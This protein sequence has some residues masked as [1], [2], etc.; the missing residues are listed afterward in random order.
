MKVPS[1]FGIIVIASVFFLT[2]VSL[3]YAAESS[4]WAQRN[5]QMAALPVGL[6]LPLAYTLPKN[7]AIGISAQYATIQEE[8]LQKQTSKNLQK[9]IV[10]QDV[11][12]NNEAQ[13]NIA[14]VVEDLITSQKIDMVALEGAFEPLDFGVY[15]A[16]PNTD[17][18][19]DI[20]KYFL[21]EKLIGGPSF[22]G[23]THKNK[24]P[25]FVG[26]DDVEHYKANVQAYLNSTQ[27][28]PQIQQEL[29]KTRTE[30]AGQKK[31][32][33]NE[34][35][36]QFDQWHQAYHSGSLSLGSYIRKI[37]PLISDAPKS[38]R[39][40]MTAYELE[41]N[42]DFD[43]V[44]RER[45]TVLEKLIRKIS[46]AD[47]AQLI[48][49][50]ERYEKGHI[51]FG[52][53]YGHVDSLL[54]KNSIDLNLSPAFK[55]YIQYVILSDA[56]KPQELMPLIERLTE[57]IYRQLAKTEEEK[58]LVAQS[59]Q[60]NLT[61]KLINFDLTPAEWEKYK[62]VRRTE[63]SVPSTQYAVLSTRDFENFY[64]EAEIRSHKMV[65]NIQAAYKNI[66]NKKTGTVLLVTGGFHSPHITQLL[67]DEGLSYVLA[68]PKITEIETDGGKSY[69]SIFSR[70]KSSLDDLF[71]GTKL[72]VTPA[73][74]VFPSPQSPR[75]AF[76][77]FY[78]ALDQFLNG[79]RAP[80]LWGEYQYGVGPLNNGDVVGPPIEVGNKGKLQ[81]RRR[82]TPLL[83]RIYNGL[84]GKRKRRNN[85]YHPL[86][87]SLEARAVKAGDVASALM[88]PVE[89]PQVEEVAPP[90]NNSPAPVFNPGSIDAAFRELT[91]QPYTLLDSPENIFAVES[92]QPRAASNIFDEDFGSAL[93]DEE[94]IEAIST[95]RGVVSDDGIQFSQTGQP[96][97]F[98]VYIYGV[99]VYDPISQTIETRLP[100]NPDLFFQA[101]LSVYD[102]PA[103]PVPGSFFPMNF[104]SQ[105]LENPVVVMQTGEIQM[106]PFFE[107]GLTVGQI[108]LRGIDISN[109]NLSSP[110]MALSLQ[111]FVKSAGEFVSFSPLPNS[112]VEVFV[113]PGVSADAF[114]FNINFGGLFVAAIAPSPLPTQKT[115]ALK[116]E[117]QPEQR[118]NLG[119][120]VQLILPYFAQPQWIRD[121]YGRPAPEFKPRPGDPNEVPDQA[122]PSAPVELLPSEIFKN[123]PD[124]LERLS[125][126]VYIGKLKHLLHQTK[127]NYVVVNIPTDNPNLKRVEILITS[128]DGKTRLWSGNPQEKIA[129]SVENDAAYIVVILRGSNEEFIA[130]DVKTEA[131]VTTEKPDQT[132][133]MR[134]FNPANFK[135]PVKPVLP[136]SPRVDGN[137]SGPLDGALDKLESAMNLPA[138]SVRENRPAPSLP[139]PPAPVVVENKPDNV[140]AVTKNVQQD[141]PEVLAETAE[142]RSVL[143]NA[144]KALVVFSAAAAVYVLS[145]IIIRLFH[146]VDWRAPLRI[147]DQ[148]FSYF[149]VIVASVIARY[150]RVP[151]PTVFPPVRKP[152]KPS[153]PVEKPEP[154]QKPKPRRPDP[155]AKPKDK[156][157]SPQLSPWKPADGVPSLEQAKKLATE[158]G[159]N[160]PTSYLRT[161]KPAMKPY[162]L[163]LRIGLLNLMGVNVE[164]VKQ[165][166]DENGKRVRGYAFNTIPLA[167]L[168][169]NR[170]KVDKEKIGNALKWFKEVEV[171]RLGSEKNLEQSDYFVLTDTA[172]FLLREEG[173]SEAVTE[174]PEPKVVRGIIV[175][176]PI[177][178]VPQKN[179]RAVQYWVAHQFWEPETA[180]SANGEIEILSS[181]REKINVSQTLF[182]QLDIRL[183]LIHPELGKSK[184]LSKDELFFSD[185]KIS[186]NLYTK[187]YSYLVGSAEVK[188]GKEEFKK[189]QFNVQINVSNSQG[190]SQFNSFDTSSRLYGLF[191]TLIPINRVGL[192]RV[193][194]V[195]KNNVKQNSTTR[196]VIAP[197]DKTDQPFASGE[198]NSLLT[199][200]EAEGIEEVTILLDSQ[201]M[202]SVGEIYKALK[203]QE[204]LKISFGSIEDY[205][206]PK[207]LSELLKNQNNE[208]HARVKFLIEQ[209]APVTEDFLN[210]IEVVAE[211]AGDNVV[212]LHILLGLTLGALSLDVNLLNNIS[213]DRQILELIRSQA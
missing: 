152:I 156:L 18:A 101:T 165:L 188:S 72:F 107:S 20:A 99:N 104:N 189:G 148:G 46:S 131:T 76:G 27:V 211:E 88:A 47:V 28:K 23:L 30:L 124:S 170:M 109:L 2:Q 132:V 203:K 176:Q 85:S 42:I 95:L 157:K 212:S 207:N 90:I 21:D 161:E 94:V 193:G 178:E 209:G 102:D 162:E 128:S 71:S 147:L 185:G 174:K 80:F 24:I 45:N 64:Q 163:R 115:N 50:N 1:R 121:R 98:E 59:E 116:F 143:Q 149:S 58:K 145:P 140:P 13:K 77:V 6:S 48:Q 122:P 137:N 81:L 53:F 91:V 69:L 83:T 12:L 92:N 141:T 194:H 113:S 204:K 172:L 36:Y 40:F 89:T 139:V 196:I 200:I 166:R 123:L 14:Q 84:F 153:G 73:S 179:D 61:Q 111:T 37:S 175:D 168:I 38:V 182:D 144:V 106:A 205:S 213:Q 41:E 32:T 5:T 54:K 177:T 105:A 43:Q 96:Y 171:E 16:L 164:E 167:H 78:A 112:N 206:Q 79:I 126:N 186:F 135:F 31:R 117:P 62:S 93:I 87:E 136:V 55:N 125:V 134:Q 25:A 29:N 181:N 68:Q 119:G 15:R 154:K 63:Y 100:T 3:P 70:E 26:V 180:F 103:E 9:V 201:R 190:A 159:L 138:P 56:I 10:L 39:N 146:R 160:I 86:F 191:N 4:F 151:L 60:V 120:G 210:A 17:L 65:Q 130:Y 127:Q 114:Q 197:K 155:P 202:D 110:R 22:V 67:K 44:E 52:E 187:D 8:V 158:M 199:Q 66:K 118:L 198:L 142:Q 7:S 57:S 11:H 150:P 195:I 97:E 19:G 192:N 183:F 74:T 133:V 34:A 184:V 35:L 82:P 51:R 129:L 173:A 75:Q 208:K 169:K 108:N 33:F 49:E